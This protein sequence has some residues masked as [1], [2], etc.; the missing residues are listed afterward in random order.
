MEITKA[1]KERRT[2][3]PVF[4]DI[5]EDCMEI[6]RENNLPIT[7]IQVANYLVNLPKK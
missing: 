6:I 5:F 1:E 4:G 3:Y 2:R 7:P